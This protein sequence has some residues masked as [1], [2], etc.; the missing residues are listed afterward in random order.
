M[1][2][3]ILGEWRKNRNDRINSLAKKCKVQRKT[4]S[5]IIKLWSEGRGLERKIFKEIKSAL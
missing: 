4:D 3:F 1:R 5:C 2:K